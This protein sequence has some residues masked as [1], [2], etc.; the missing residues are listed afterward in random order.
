MSFTFQWRRQSIKQIKCYQETK[1]RNVDRNR[2]F[3]K[4]DKLREGL[5]GKPYNSETSSNHIRGSE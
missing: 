4:P 5:P 1:Q 2:P 3:S